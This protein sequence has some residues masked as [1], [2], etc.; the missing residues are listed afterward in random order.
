[1]SC[2]V[3]KPSGGFGSKRAALSVPLRVQDG[4]RQPESPTPGGRQGAVELSRKQ[5]RP[6]HLDPARTAGVHGAFHA[7]HPAPR[8]RPGADLWLVASGRQ[9]ARQPRPGPAQPAT[10]AHRRRGASV[11]PTGV[12]GLATGGW[13]KGR[14][15]FGTPLPAVSASDAT[16]RLLGSRKTGALSQT[17]AMNLCQPPTCIPA[18]REPDR[19]PVDS[20]PRW[21]W[22]PQATLPPGPRSSVARQRTFSLPARVVLWRSCRSGM[23]PPLAGDGGWQKLSAKPFASEDPLNF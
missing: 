21:K 16:S 14:G 18:K 12:S 6:T 3:L 17:T 5:K 2:P 8:F 22:T 1:M 11:E 9:S 7:T 10:L 23:M 19:E 15:R 20:A 4:H 13:S